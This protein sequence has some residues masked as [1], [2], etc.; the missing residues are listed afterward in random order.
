[1]KGTYLICIHLLESAQIKYGKKFSFKFPVG[2]YVYVGSALGNSGSS[3]LLNR[4]K[5]HVKNP[6][7]KRNQWHIDYF[8][9]SRKTYIQSLYIIPSEIRLECQIAQE[10]SQ[11]SDHT[12]NDFGSSDCDCNGHLFYFKE[13]KGFKE[14]NLKLDIKK[15]DLS[16]SSK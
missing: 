10:L 4:V 6:K 11:I 5:R 14:E 7:E 3:T 9:A 16:I 13:F 8:L 1:M 12:I 15:T 2:D